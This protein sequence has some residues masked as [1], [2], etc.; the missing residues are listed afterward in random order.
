MIN[1]T[2]YFNEVKYVEYFKRTWHKQ[3][4]VEISSLYTFHN[5]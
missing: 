4:H 2:K 1:Q 5:N 3:Y